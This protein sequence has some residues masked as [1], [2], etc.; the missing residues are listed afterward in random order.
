M[1]HRL[2]KLIESWKRKKVM[3]ES[4]DEGLC[5][6]DKANTETIATLDECISELNAVIDGY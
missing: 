2:E 1:Q 4:E 6:R 5:R 3:L